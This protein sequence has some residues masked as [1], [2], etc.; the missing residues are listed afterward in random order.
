MKIKYL[1]GLRGVAALIVVFCHLRYTCFVTYQNNLNSSIYNLPILGILKSFLVGIVNLFLDGDLAV[2]IFWILSSYVISILFF[3]RDGEY[4][5]IVISYFSKRYFRLLF[6]VLASI[7]F[8]YLLLK[9]GLMYNIKLASLLGPPYLNGW[10]DSLYTFDP[11]FI[12]AIK[13][14]FFTTFFNF[15]YSSSYNAVLWTI[16]N[17]FLGSLFTFSIFGIIRHNKRRFLLYLLI[18]LVIFKLHLLWLF[19]F[20]VGHILCDYQFSASNDKVLKYIRSIELKIHRF[21]ISVF[22]LS[23]LF[24]ILGRSIMIYV[25]IPTEYQN[26]ILSIFTVYICTKN[27]YFQTI[28]SAKIPFWLGNISFSMYLIHLPIICSLTSFLVLTH[29][30]LQGKILASI[31]T[32]VVV[33]FLSHFFTKYIDKKG[34]IFAN[35]I[36]DYFKRYS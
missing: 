24:I 32:L 27:T 19:A 10:L 15:Q 2:W 35:K 17:E 12:K 34:V 33:F 8:A 7:L 25:K 20:V 18:L 29:C 13:S 21:G 14:A 5:K 11:N 31:L 4:D 26:L 28:F 22:I 30:S 6:P 16:Q 9:F 3:K 1:E 36:G 23:L